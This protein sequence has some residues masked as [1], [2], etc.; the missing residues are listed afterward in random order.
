[1]FGSSNLS[2]R[3][4]EIGLEVRFRTVRGDVMSNAS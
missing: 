2:I 1:V 4:I 3:V